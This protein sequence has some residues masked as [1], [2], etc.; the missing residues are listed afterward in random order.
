[1]GSVSD[2][3]ISFCA[4]FGVA[5]NELNAKQVNRTWQLPVGILAFLSL[6]FFFLVQ[7]AKS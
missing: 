7:L 3:S 5:F 2:R 6:T 1:M 4:S